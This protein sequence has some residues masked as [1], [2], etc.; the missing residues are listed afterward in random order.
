MDVE[1]V[2]GQ[3]RARIRRRGCWQ[4]RRW[5]LKGSGPGRWRAPRGSS[6]GPVSVRSRRRAAWP[7]VPQAWRYIL[8]AG[9]PESAFGWLLVCRELGL[10]A[11]EVGRAHEM[12]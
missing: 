2:R 5:R 12:R 3:R 10:L 8:A 9:K 11:R 6:R 1:R 7:R 4:P